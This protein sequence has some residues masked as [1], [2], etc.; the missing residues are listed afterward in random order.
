MPRAAGLVLCAIVL[1]ASA[2]RPS[3]LPYALGDREFWSLIES[4]SEPPG[5]FPLSDNIV[6]NEPRFADSVRW[7]RPLGGVYI[8]VGPE[9]NFSYIAALQPT[10]AFVIDIRRENLDL[11]LLYKALFELSV[12]RAD[13]VSRLFSRVRPAGLGPSD[14]VDEIFRRFDGV[15]PSL[16]LY[17]AT[18]ALVRERLLS[19][20]SLPLA[21]SDLEWIERA[22]RMFS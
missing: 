18:V 15:P 1:A 6:S 4:L 19:T 20:R 7:L 21:P 2:C 16:E 8:G 22:L 10:M 12:D 17:A 11:H 9:Q 3:S 5:A 13:F 14:S